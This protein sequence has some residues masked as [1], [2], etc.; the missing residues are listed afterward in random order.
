MKK[1]HQPDDLLKDSTVLEED[2]RDEVVDR[3]AGLERRR[4]PGRRGQR[5]VTGP[6]R[7][8][9]K[10]LDRW[11]RR[12]GA[13][14]HDQVAIADLAPINVD[15][16]RPG[17]AALATDQRH[18]APLDA[19]RCSSVIAMRRKHITAPYRGEVSGLVVVKGHRRRCPAKLY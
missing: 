10:A 5:L 9:V 18:A 16:A 3:R 11:D 14:C 19:P 15:H 6:D 7:H 12:T 13:R 4:G 17:D 1:P 2:R 8:L